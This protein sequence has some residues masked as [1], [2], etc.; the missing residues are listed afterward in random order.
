MRDIS[1]HRMIVKF[2][3]FKDEVILVFE[4]EFT[5]S[6]FEIQINQRSYKIDA[7]EYSTVERK[8]V[9]KYS[10]KTWMFRLWNLSAKSECVTFGK[11]N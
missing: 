5:D 8:G 2:E 9:N 11:K 4:S 7:F 6:G 3:V 1:L 10:L